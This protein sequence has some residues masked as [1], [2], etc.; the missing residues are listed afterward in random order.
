MVEY[1][2]K[3]IRC[4]YVT[5]INSIGK[6]IYKTKCKWENKVVGDTTPSPPRLAGS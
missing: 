3:I 2:R 1:Y 5:K 6:C 4:R